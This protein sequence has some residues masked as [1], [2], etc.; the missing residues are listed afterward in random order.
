MRP[1]VGWKC[2]GSNRSRHWSRQESLVSP[3]RLEIASPLELASRAADFLL[4]L[5]TNEGSQRTVD[6]FALSLESS[7]AQRVFH[8]FVVDDDIGTHCSVYEIGKLYTSQALPRMDSSRS[9]KPVVEMLSHL[10]RGEGSVSCNH[11]SHQR[12][13]FRQGFGDAAGFEQRVV[14]GILRR[15]SQSNS[16]K[17]ESQ[18]LHR[19]H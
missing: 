5:K 12:T 9:L 18:N 2:L 1:T 6:C 19:L 7:G 17:R 15:V 10:R 4:L 3:H 11:R 16:G 8:K 14:P 13:V